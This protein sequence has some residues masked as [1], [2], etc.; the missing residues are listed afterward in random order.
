MQ[1]VVVVV[2]VFVVVS[3]F[4]M[5]RWLCG[6]ISVIQGLSVGCIQ[7]ALYGV[8]IESPYF[9]PMTIRVKDVY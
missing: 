7:G 5:V 9:P 6:R 4:D 3:K 2:A 1:L 8:L